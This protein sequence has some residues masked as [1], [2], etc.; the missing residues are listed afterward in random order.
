MGT[1][2]GLLSS[3]VPA[4]AIVNGTKA[5]RMPPYMASL[6]DGNRQQF[7]GG[8]ILDDRT[9][10]T[11]AH[12]LE[13]QSP[14]SALSV[15]VG[16]LQLDGATLYLVEKYVVHPQYN[17]GIA[18]NNDVAVLKLA[19][20]LIFKPGSVGPV[21]WPRSSDQLP[22]GQILSV[23]GWGLLSDGGPAPKDLYTTNVMVLRNDEQGCSN[24]SREGR[25]SATMFCAGY[26][27]GHTDACQGDS[28]GPL[29]N[30]YNELVG[31]VSW[32]EGCAR[33]GWAGVYTDVNRLSSWIS[34]NR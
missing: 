16:S 29:V 2:L 24:Y 8:V 17:M 14:S 20:P 13:R 26:P 7:C 5:T 11:A 31:I 32:G 33:P 23:A 28:G 9:V 30:K 27:D 15:G 21:S 19:T 12:C 18:F 10:L 6:R 22:Y 34:A 4:H 3:T 25:L 1:L